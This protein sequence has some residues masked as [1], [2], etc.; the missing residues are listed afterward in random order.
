M[1]GL[2]IIL[3]C[4]LFVSANALA[5]AQAMSADWHRVEQLPPHTRVHISSDKMNRLCLIDSV[6]EESLICSSGHTTNSFPRAEIKSIK[7]TRYVLSTV[8]GAG[9]GAGAGAIIGAAATT[10]KTNGIG[11]T[12][13]EVV[14]IF[15]LG[16][17]LVGAVVGGPTDFLRGPTVYRRPK[18]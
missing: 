11:A 13:G 5:Q 8:G 12:R 10:G 4:V 2:F 16:G 3:N 18:S 6:A 9:I 14:G 17:A 15:T 7:V 1:R